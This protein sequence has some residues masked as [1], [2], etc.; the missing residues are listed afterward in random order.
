MPFWKKALLAALGTLVLVIGLAIAGI[1]YVGNMI[2]GRDHLSDQALI[3]KLHQ[4]RAKYALLI[5]MFRQDSP[6]QVVH[7]TFVHPAGAI[8]PQRWA[9]YK[10]LFTELG[11]D[12]GMRAWEGQ[13]I[14]F[15]ST[16]QGLV[17][18]GSSKGYMYKP[19]APKPLFRN[20][21]KIPAELPSNVRGYRKID[22][23]WY[24]TVDWDD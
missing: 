24:I 8:T 16:A 21:D 19:S 2:H 9:Q 20:L 22:D 23:D 10:V 7:P 11:L 4:D 5:E 3:D 6:V 14:W 17:T 1:V 13:E 18:G 12:A 15:I